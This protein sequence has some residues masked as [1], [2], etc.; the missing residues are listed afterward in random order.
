MSAPI[1]ASQNGRIDCLAVTAEAP[2]GSVLDDQFRLSV[3]GAA[4]VACGATA[5][6][7]EKTNAAT[8]RAD[9]AQS[10]PDVKSAVLLA[11]DRSCHF[12][13]LMANVF[14][15]FLQLDATLDSSPS[16]HPASG[17]Q[18]VGQ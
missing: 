8:Q 6:I 5:V 4:C 12:E 1:Q 18:I 7:D 14:A 15:R 9:L 16:A 11:V 13:G 17:E 2:F 10:S 3:A